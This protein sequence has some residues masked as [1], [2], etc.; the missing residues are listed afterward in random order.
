M[1]LKKLGSLKEMQDD[2]ILTLK[3]ESKAE[4]FEKYKPEEFK[5][6]D[7][8]KNDFANTAALLEDPFVEEKEDD[9]KTEERKKLENLYVKTLTKVNENEL[10]EGIIVGI[11][12]KEV[13]VNIGYKSEGVININELRYNPDIK[14]G[15]KIDVI[16]ETKENENGQLVLSHKKA[17]ALKAWQQ[18]LKAHEENQTIQGYIKCRTKGGM[19]VD[20]WGIEAFLP[21]SQLDT[22]P[23]KD[24]DSYVGKTLDLKV[25]KIN[26]ELKNVVVS[27]KAVI[28]EIENEQKK[29]IIKKLEPGQILLGKV[30][31]ITSYGVFVDLGG[32]DGLIYINDLSWRRISHPEEVVKLGQEINVVVLGYNEE[33]KHVFLGYK[34]LQPHPWDLLDPSI[35]VGKIVKGK[36]VNLIDSGAFVEIFPG[37]EGFIHVSEISWSHHLHSAFDFFKIGDEVEAIITYFN[38]DERK[39]NLSIKQLKPDPW[40]NIEKKYPLKS[41]HQGTVKNFSNLGIIIELEEGIEGLLHISDLSWTKKYR[42]PSEFCKIGDKIDVMI[43]NIDKQNRRLALGH[44]QLE[45]NPWDTITTVF[46]VGEIYSGTVIDIKEKFAKIQLPYGIEA[47]ATIKNIIKQDGTKLQVGEKADFKILE[48][49]KEDKRIEVSHSRVYLDAQKEE[50]KKEYKKFKAEKSK[51]TKTTIGDI[52]ELTGLK[53]QLFLDDDEN[54]KKKTN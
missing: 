22:K 47:I 53:E 30:K 43:L 14:I 29:E 37:V 45:E 44:K 50:A 48:I 42:H 10:I 31:N 13:I 51:E 7:G 41:K 11:T 12:K 23:V 5:E 35:N 27:H 18:I 2:E 46:K 26:H 39:I 40:L 6:I 9:I 17:K 25:V 38:K 36:V 20:L 21:G 28:E 15:D 34:Q 1:A 8:L 4:S 32:I 3:E 52:L 33:K 16:I 19:I 24:Y 54:N 49:S